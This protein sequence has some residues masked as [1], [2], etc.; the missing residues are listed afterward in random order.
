MILQLSL[1]MTNRLELNWKLDGFV[2]EQRY[3]CS[4]MPI[5]INNLPNPK[6]I[7]A[8][9]IRSYA[10]TD[11]NAEKTYY[12]CVSSVRNNVEKVSDIHV[13]TPKTYH[14]WLEFSASGIVKKGTSSVQFNNSGCSFEQMSDG[15]YAARFQNSNTYLY[16]SAGDAIVGDFELEMVYTP[17]AFANF[18][19]WYDSRESAGWAV[20]GQI[21]GFNNGGAYIEFRNGSATWAG[22]GLSTDKHILNKKTK[23]TF[24]RI[25]TIWK[26][27]IDDEFIA[28]LPINDPY[29][30]NAL[31]NQT[32]IGRV[33]DGNSDYYLNGYLHR[34]SI[35]K[36]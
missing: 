19:A 4:E 21:L 2:D 22:A 20:N 1:K 10:D 30:S 3:Y 18:G 36:L 14:V 7:L 35:R 23:V 11:I 13:I 17:L 8:N 34:W 5:D 25:G 9:D 29:L 32:Y 33:K 24:R 28:D 6:A 12:V 16:S 27:Y 31:Q 26:Y 15:T